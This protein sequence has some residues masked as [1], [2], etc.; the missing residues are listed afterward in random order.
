MAYIGTKTG[1]HLFIPSSFDSITFTGDGTTTQYTLPR[2]I[3][4]DEAILIHIDGV[5]QHASSAYSTSGTSL[6]FTGAPPNASSI[7]AI[8][9]GIGSVDIYAPSSNT[10]DVSALKTAD[11]GSGDVLVTDGSGNLSFSDALETAEIFAL[12]GL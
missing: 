9:F 12:V 4:N 8:I 6:T 10:V 3:V 7:E 2:S 11:G 1:G 5:K